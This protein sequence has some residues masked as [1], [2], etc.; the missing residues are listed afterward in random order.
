MQYCLDR[1]NVF[2]ILTFGGMLLSIKYRSNTMP[3]MLSI[4]KIKPKMME[5][6]ENLGVT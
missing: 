3:K 6:F 4:H 2:L 5:G 1:S